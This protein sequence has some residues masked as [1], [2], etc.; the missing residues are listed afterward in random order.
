MKISYSIRISN[1]AEVV[2]QW[3]SSPE[4]A[5]VWMKSVSE[6]AYINKTENMI[7]TTFRET[8]E[9]NGKKLEMEGIVTNCVNNKLISFHMQ[10]KI[11]VFDVEYSI[12]ETV[13]GVRLVATSDIKWKFPMNIICL[14]T[15]PKIKRNI[16]EQSAKEFLKLKELCETID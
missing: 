1:K 14:I 9:E 5:K 3:L 16:M 7:G 13:D 4:K 15:G 2:F 6:T 10:S 11:H 12:E 8:V